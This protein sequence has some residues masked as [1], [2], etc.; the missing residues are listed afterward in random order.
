[1]ADLQKYQA[2]I[3]DLDGTAIPNTPQGAPSTKLIETVQDTL[4]HSELRLCAA[5]GRTIPKAKYIFDMLKLEDP[6]V[7]S[8]GTQI[9]DP[10]TYE[11]LWQVTMS[12]NDVQTILEACSPF[13]YEILIG[14]EVSG[15][16]APAAQR[17]AK[18]DINVMYIMACSQADAAV[19]MSELSKISDIIAVDVR[20]WTHEGVDI[21]V[22]HKDATKEHA[23]AE[24]LKL[25]NIPK[26]ATIGVGDG[27]NDVHLFR[28]VG[29][30]VAMGN[31]TELLKSQAD[32]ICPPVD[33][34]GLTEVIER[35]N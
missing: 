9:V 12:K 21:H 31:A 33:D 19:I 17:Q 3:F 15:E 24:L 6:C 13:K 10:K 29:H 26:E 32:E 16:G 4:A 34:D 30:R 1:M 5:T 22:T 8:A 20:S 18:S 11:I 2:I 23:I 35:Y 14:E 27:N 25:L 7:I 28:A